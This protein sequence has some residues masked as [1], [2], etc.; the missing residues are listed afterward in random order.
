VVAEINRLDRPARVLVVDDE[1]HI[2]RL[3]EFIL[4]REGYE[5]NIAYSGEQALVQA[6]KV[7]PDLVL[8]DLMLP[9]ISG[10][11]VLKRLKS[12][13]DRPT[14]KVVVL[15]GRSFEADSQG[16][17]ESGASCQC[18]KP[19]APSTLIRKLLDLGVPPRVAA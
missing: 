16:M 9:G 3:M 13:E 7:R 6:D 1:R 5:V 10:L 8:L 18:T 2:A 15:T 4:K 17:I 12:G 14:M 19:I 11:E